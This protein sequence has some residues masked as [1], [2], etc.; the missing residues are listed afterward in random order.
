[1]SFT[2]HATHMAAMRILAVNAKLTTET[3]AAVLFNTPAAVRAA[4]RWIVEN[5][6]LGFFSYRPRSEGVNEDRAFLQQ[7]LLEYRLTKVFIPLEAATIERLIGGFFGADLDY[8][9]YD[10]I[11]PDRNPR[12]AG[13]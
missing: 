10:V 5:D 4:W 1:M 8:K 12:N 9:I 3:D 11:N 13:L 6:R 2:P 7:Y